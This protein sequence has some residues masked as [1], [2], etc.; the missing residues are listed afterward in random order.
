[1]ARSQIGSNG[2]KRAFLPDAERFIGS[3]RRECLDHIM[4]FNEASLRQILKAHFEYY[5]YTSS[6]VIFGHVLAS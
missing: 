3:L 4:V 5:E 2:L 1:M 6:A